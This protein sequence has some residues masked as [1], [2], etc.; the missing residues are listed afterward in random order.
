M[1]SKSQNIKQEENVVIDIDNDDQSSGSEQVLKT[2][3]K[4]SQMKG[5]PTVAA[6][7]AVTHSSS[8][9]PTNINCLNATDLLSKFDDLSFENKDEH[10]PDILKK[11]KEHANVI[12][13]NVVLKEVLHFIL[14]L[15][16]KFNANKQDL[17]KSA[18][19]KVKMEKK[20]QDDTAQNTDFEHRWDDFK[21][22][23]SNFELFLHE[24]NNCN[25]RSNSLKK[26]K[27]D[28]EDPEV[29][30]KLDEEIGKSKKLLDEKREKKNE[31]EK[32]ISTTDTEME[33]KVKSKYQ[34]ADISAML[35]F[36]WDKLNQDDLS[37][38]AQLKNE[39]QQTEKEISNGENEIKNLEGIQKQANELISI[40]VQDID[41]RLKT[42]TEEEK[43]QKKEFLESVKQE[44]N[45]IL[46]RFIDLCKD[47]HHIR[48]DISRLK[49]RNLKNLTKSLDEET[50]K[51][52]KLVKAGSE[53]LRSIWT[54]LQK[55]KEKKKN[56]VQEVWKILTNE[57]K[58]FLS[59]GKIDEE[60]SKELEAL[61]GSGLEKQIESNGD[62]RK[63]ADASNST[64]V[65]VA[66][67][68]E[69]PP[70]S[71]SKKRVVRDDENE[72]QEE[73]ENTGSKKQKNESEGSSGCSLQ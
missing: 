34:K 60:F 72:T 20:S 38:R 48:S 25:S 28:V 64:G 3:E 19:M 7:A 44:Y 36:C 42:F 22:N 59:N 17:A 62:D 53:S 73:D 55:E 21:E 56:K 69:S 31:M 4:N 30:K 41:S 14:G 39:L 6:I 5:T 49:E 65:V 47:T 54:K 33:E 37:R 51:H 29:F 52:Q 10:I 40:L 70:S 57:S 9:S 71:S 15:P 63:A 66:A 13:T 24:I 32:K 8:C 46:T 35:D 16:L 12:S 50:E 11:I 27:K 68:L 67:D 18:E 1:S 43:R 23:C 45:S 61:F 26:L 2:P 58:S